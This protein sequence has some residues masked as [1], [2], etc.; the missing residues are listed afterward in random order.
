MLGNGRK[1]LKILGPP[2]SNA[3]RRTKEM[4][5]NEVMVRQRRCAEE[6]TQLRRRKRGM[7]EECE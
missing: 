3:G 6:S 5:K 1:G 2:L 4:V 7:G